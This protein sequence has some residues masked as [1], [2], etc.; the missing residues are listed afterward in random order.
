LACLGA[1]L[2]VTAWCLRRMS[3]RFGAGN[4]AAGALSV[5]T[6]LMIVLSPFFPGASYLPLWPLAGAALGTGVLFLSGAPGTPPAHW[7][8][9]A[10]TLGAVPGL[11]LWPGL[12]YALYTCLTIIFAA[13]PCAGAALILGL[14]AVPLAS[15]SLRAARVG[16][17]LAAAAAVLGLAWGAFWPGFSAAQPQLTN[18]AYAL[19]ADTGKA[20]WLSS[21]SEPNPWTIAYIPKGTARERADEFFPL[22]IG[23]I[24]GDRAPI[25]MEY[26][27]APAPTLE[28]IPPRIQVVG[29]VTESG[30]RRLTLHVDSPRGAPVMM[31]YAS[32]ETKVLGG[33]VEGIP[34]LPVKGRWFLSYSILPQAGITLALEVEAGSHVR[35]RA[36][37]HSYGFPEGQVQPRPEWMGP[38]PNTPDFNRDPLKSDETVLG[39]TYEF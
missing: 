2:L 6:L 16:Y 36:V 17:A 15:L 11:L 31:L 23:P 12:L 27:R 8:I 26:R 28:L 3:A 30:K 38:K 37:E 13:I 5:W 32:P 20:W 29:D 22:G 33:A 18:M 10:A 14:L 35:L 1:T 4:A 34:L 7:A 19:D 25:S 39:K 9:A 24:A 21:D